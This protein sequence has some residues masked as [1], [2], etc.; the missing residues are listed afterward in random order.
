VHS[1]SLKI[2]GVGLATIAVALTGEAVQAAP[3]LAWQSAQ[4]LPSHGSAAVGEPAAGP[5]WTLANLG[6]AASAPLQWLIDGPAAGEFSFAAGHTCV[7]GLALAPGAKCTVQL[8]FHPQGTGAREARLVLTSQTGLDPAA[9]EGRGI[10]A[11]F[12]DLRSLPASLVF[13][14]RTNTVAGPQ[15]VRLRND[16]ATGLQIATLGIEGAAFSYVASAADSCAGELRVLLPGE[17]CEISVAWDG[18]AAGV[19]GGRLLAGAAPG[20]FGASAPLLVREDPAQRTNVGGGGAWNWPWLLA[21]AVL[22]AIGRAV[23]TESPH[24]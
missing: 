6:N 23:R 13:Q 7:P 18:S 3:L 20:A 1:G 10:A 24:A 11:A 21:L 5:V 14:A 12:G 22:L 15:W 19:L 8:T 16:G 2:D 9:L 17:E 4:M